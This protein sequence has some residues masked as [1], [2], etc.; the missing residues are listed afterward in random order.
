MCLDPPRRLA[1]VFVVIFGLDSNDAVSVQG[2][3]PAAHRQRLS[4]ARTAV[5]GFVERR[6]E[7]WDGDA[8]SGGLRCRARRHR[9]RPG[10]CIRPRIQDN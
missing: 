4:R 9:T 5:R 3:T 2:I 10:L 1:Y 7:T 6:C 8:D